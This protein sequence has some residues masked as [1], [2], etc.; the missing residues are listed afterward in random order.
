MSRFAAGC[1]H[2]CRRI[3]GRA[4]IDADAVAALIRSAARVPRP[5]LP[6]W[7]CRKAAQ[8]EHE[9]CSPGDLAW[10]VHRGS[11]NSSRG[12]NQILAGLSCC[13]QTLS[14]W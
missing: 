12:K 1:H 8:V 14:M 5:Q 4:E 9:A 11:V 13:S 6:P 7:S 2:R 3:A 10:P